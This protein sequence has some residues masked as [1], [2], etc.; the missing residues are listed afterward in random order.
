MSNTQDTKSEIADYLKTIENEDEISL[1]AKDR[2]TNLM[3]QQIKAINPL[4]SGNCHICCRLSDRLLPAVM[5]TC[6][7]CVTKFLKQGPVSVKEV[8]PNMIYCDYCFGKSFGRYNINLK[9][10]DYCSKRIGRRHKFQLKD[11]KKLQARDKKYDRKIR[12][13]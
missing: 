5:N 13:V 8:S 4:K 11:T 7:S 10:C 2:V 12:R 9:V 3:A 1:K 6:K